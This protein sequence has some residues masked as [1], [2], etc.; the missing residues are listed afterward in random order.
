MLNPFSM[1]LIMWIPDLPKISL[2]TRFPSSLPQV[3][4]GRGWKCGREAQRYLGD[5]SKFMKIVNSVCS[6]RMNRP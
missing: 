5:R 3:I 1:P 2:K 4:E 6:G